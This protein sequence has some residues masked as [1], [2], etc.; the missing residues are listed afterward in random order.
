MHADTAYNKALLLRSTTVL[1]PLQLAVAGK[2]LYMMDA[3]MERKRNF[4]EL[5]IA[6]SAGVCSMA[7]G[8]VIAITFGSPLCN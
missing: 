8:V 5:W 2:N 3:A 1:C 7:I 6:F 4:N